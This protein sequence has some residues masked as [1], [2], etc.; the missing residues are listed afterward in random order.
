MNC[1]PQINSLKDLQDGWYMLYQTLDEH[2]NRS[3]DFALKNNEFEAKELFQIFI[4][5]GFMGISLIQIHHGDI[6]LKEI[7]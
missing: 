2:G 6:L 1:N 4:N 5:D 3:W 7:I